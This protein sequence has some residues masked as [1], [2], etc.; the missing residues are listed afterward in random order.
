MSPKPYLKI[1]LY[2]THCTDRSGGREES[3]KRNEIHEIMPTN[4]IWRKLSLGS[5][6]W[7]TT[8]DENL[9]EDK[10]TSRSLECNKFPVCFLI[11][12]RYSIT[13]WEIHRWYCQPYNGVLYFLSCNLGQFY[14]PLYYFVL[15]VSNQGRLLRMADNAFVISWVFCKL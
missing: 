7:H 14:Q 6:P 1:T 10:V 12:L 4:T 15:C 8:N 3:S 13:Q 5:N 2:H 11:L 9:T